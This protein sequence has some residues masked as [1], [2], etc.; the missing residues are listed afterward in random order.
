MTLSWRFEEMARRWTMPVIGILNI[1]FG[2]VA[3]WY[4]AAMIQIHWNKWPG[5][6]TRN[7]WGIFFLLAVVSMYLVVHLAYCGIRLIKG[8]ETALLPC[9]LLFAA[10]T[11][12]VFVSVWVLWMMLPQ[13]MNKVIFGL[14]SVALSPIDIEVLYGYSPLGFVVTLTL[15]L[16]RRNLLTK[17]T[18]DEAAKKKST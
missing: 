8:D 1:L 15:L 2:I 7:D 9:F 18:A 17:L 13:S 11:F 3:S 12:G 16:S 5:S 14:W 6:A 4:F 10:E